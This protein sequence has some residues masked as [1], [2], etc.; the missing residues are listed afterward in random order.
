MTA[1]WIDFRK[2]ALSPNDET[3]HD[4]TGSKYA[5]RV[6]NMSKIGPNSRKTAHFWAPVYNVTSIF[7]EVI[8]ITACFYESTNLEIYPFLY[9][10][11]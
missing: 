4:L 11:H 1:Q 10:Q 7:E 3:I 8:F 2:F 9:T 6:Q 5:K